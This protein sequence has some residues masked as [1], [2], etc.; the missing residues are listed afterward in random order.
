MAD[1]ILVGVGA[2]VAEFQRDANQIVGI[3]KALQRDIARALQGTEIIPD[4]SADARLAGTQIMGGLRAAVQEGGDALQRDVAAALVPTNLGPE[5][6]RL[7]GLVTAGTQNISTALAREGHEAGIALVGGIASE[8]PAVQQ[9]LSQFTR[10][11]SATLSGRLLT[12]LTPE[13]ARAGRELV[14]GLRTAVQAQQ[15]SLRADIVGSLIPTS[16]T[17]DFSRLTTSIEGSAATLARALGAGG[18]NAGRQMVLGLSS[19]LTGADRVIATFVGSVS[20]ELA[21]ANLLG[22][23]GRQGELSGGQLVRGVTAAITSGGTSIQRAVSASLVPANLPAQLAII[24]TGVSRQIATLTPQ[25]SATGTLAGRALVA[26]LGAELSQGTAIIVREFSRGA[27]GAVAG[28]DLFG[29][30]TPAGQRA[31]TQLLSG[32]TQVVTREGNALRGTLAT[33]LIPST[34][35]GELGRLT[36]TITAGLGGIPPLFLT[37]GRDSGAAFAGALTTQLGTTRAVLTTFARET[38][39]AITGALTIG[40]VSGAGI[41]AGRMLAGS[42]A[43]GIT[44]EAPRIR[45]A[46]TGALAPASVTTEVARITGGVVTELRAVTP[47]VA[48]I[49]MQQGQAY[50]GAIQGVVAQNTGVFRQ[51]T[52]GSQ[53]GV[54]ID[55]AP[56]RATTI[57]VEELAIATADVATSARQ[58]D[59]AMDAISGSGL[60]DAARQ[61]RTLADAQRQWVRESQAGSVSQQA[62]WARERNEAARATAEARRG[63]SEAQRNAQQEVAAR[64]QVRAEL[65]N[66][67]ATLRQYGATVDATNADSL[68]AWRAEAAAIRR[69]AQEVGLAR[70]QMLRLDAVI[71]R[72]E[73]SFARQQAAA[74]R[75]SAAVSAGAGTGASAAALAGI[76]R[77]ANE[78]KTA[79][80]GVTVAG[81]S[82][83]QIS[84]RLGPALVG[85][86]FGL[87][88]LA[89]GGDAAESGVR[90]ALRAVA[91]FATFF[92]TPGF[93]VAGVAASTAAILDL[94]G[95]ARKQMEETRKVFTQ[96]LNQ[97]IQA[98]DFTGIQRQLRDVEQGVLEL[99]Q[100][101]GRVELSGGIRDLE[102]RANAA[103]EAIRL[104][105]A[106]NQKAASY[107]P[108]TGL[109]KPGTGPFS[110]IIAQNQAILRQL[111][112]QIQ[113]AK[114]KQKV[115]TDLLLNPPTLPR[116]ITGLPGVQVTSGAQDA[117]QAVRALAEQ[118]EVVAEAFTRVNG[119][120]ALQANIIAKAV[121]LYERIAGMSQAQGAAVTETANELAR[122][123]RTLGAIDAIQ[124][125]V[126]RRKLGGVVPDV[127]PVKITGIIDKVELP[128]A[129]MPEIPVE[130]D[131]QIFQESIR[132]A[133]EG[134]TGAQNTEVFARMFGSREAI[135]DATENV[136]AVSFNLA[137]ALT[138]EADAIRNSSESATV[139]A[140]RLEGLRAVAQAT[141]VQVKG[142][143]DDVIE[144]SS[145]LSDIGNAARSIADVGR[146]IQG[147]NSDVLDVIDSVG[148]FASALDQL[149][150][151]DFGDIFKDV[152]SL[153]KS[154]P[155]IGEAIAAAINLGRTAFNAITG[156]ETDAQNNQILRENNEQ[157]ERLRQD[158]KG[159]GDSIVELTNASS[160]I[161]ESAILRA[162]A[163]T[164]GFGRGFRDVESLDA[165][166]RAAGSSI[167]E[168]KRRAEELGITIVDAKGRISAQGL[169]ALNDAL[170]LTVRQ[171]LTFSDTLTDATFIADARREIFDMAG[172][173]AIGKDWLDQL[174]KFAPDI[175]ARFFGGAEAATAEGRAIFEQGIRDAFEAAAQ[176]KIDPEM[177]KA[178]GSVEEF[179]DFL[180]DADRAL[181]S[182][183]EATKDATGEMVNVVR[184]FRDFNMERARFQAT[185]NDA[186]G[187][188][189][190]IPTR[191][192]TT[193]SFTPSLATP[194]TTVGQVNF[195]PTIVLEDT[196][197]KNVTELATELVEELRRKARASAN[198]EVRKTVY[199]LP[200]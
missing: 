193:T 55:P 96:S 97:M 54:V 67:I 184:G 155:V 190:V 81:K 41:A 105:N 147:V 18:E 157:L 158:L 85:V 72:T 117:E 163:G 91:S 52:A 125:E 196:G 90:T 10:S 199:L 37:A 162:R 128:Q 159:F 150:G 153:L 160:A 110:A 42:I 84:T 114:R 68:A 185:A 118:V 137:R 83:Q 101:T 1:D 189:F 109:Q 178:F 86:S 17:A 148:R 78:A 51:L 3:A 62:A 46:I 175:A 24:T 134:L 80:A 26:S 115:L 7:A 33:A 39:A 130:L 6:Q 77:Q 43:S 173:D 15:G 174:R 70:D 31:G 58:A 120:A 170:Q 104:L 123:L 74:A 143:T 16:L 23:L 135:A 5:F 181:D 177:I 122:M 166:L 66:D 188:T 63:A 164:S 132:R 200:A 20:G 40:D 94:F 119:N 127:A 49:G 59:A 73:R 103:R 176:G 35:S 198:P 95:T 149:R 57:A 36:T 154:I 182:F 195:S 98:G 126:T 4:L 151:V 100:A 172:A 32:L 197:S 75:A 111:E 22:D 133:V 29:D 142:L 139:K 44:A 107:D 183:A 87:E 82:L 165:E 71:L 171:L 167:A 45:A 102:S 88:A 116:E 99:N 11:V 2:D 113:E 129:R 56:V 27:A 47:E 187:G 140:Q 146:E 194:T 144:S 25:L 92:G 61:T 169:D 48:R 53:V 89:R 191:T 28:V 14:S 64:A 19:G 124:I 136:A 192:P 60:R 50:I 12:N 186:R 156:A 138:A 152:G 121:P 161:S 13:G 131:Q 141:R 34:L 180:L 168:L 8:L 79:V 38:S 65:V 93:I 9:V 145:A 21:R 179:V 30:L 106:E 69:Q 112:P 76:T 108:K